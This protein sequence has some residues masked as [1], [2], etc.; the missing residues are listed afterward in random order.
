MGERMPFRWVG[1]DS[2]YGNSP[3]FVQGLRELD[4]CYVLDVSSDNHVWTEAAGDPTR[5]ET[6]TARGRPHVHPACR[7]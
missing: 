6:K 2:I 3:S 7:W 4:K 1:G 5:A